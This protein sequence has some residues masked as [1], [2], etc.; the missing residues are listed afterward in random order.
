MASDLDILLKEY[1][2][3]RA[4]V[5][6][7][8]RTAFSHLAFFGA[9]AAFAFQLP[10]S[11]PLNQNLVLGLS[12]FGTLF[13]LYISVINWIWVN[14]IA[15]HLRHLESKINSISKK[16]LLTWESKSYAISRWVLLPPKPYPHN[17]TFEDPD[18]CSCS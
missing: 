2:S 18:R 8:V 5:V 15:S 12:A 7:R 6:E 3:L 1:D 16:K 14:R 4:E 9:V 13:L 11:S 17:G 10:A